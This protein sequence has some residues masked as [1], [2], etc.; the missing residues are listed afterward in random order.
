MELAA[1]AF[2]DEYV[3]VHGLAGFQDD[4]VSIFGEFVGG[5]A[6]AFVSGFL[7]AEAGELGVGAAAI[8]DD[9]AV[10]G[11]DEEVVEIADEAVGAVGGRGNLAFVVD[12]PVAGFHDVFDAEGLGGAAGAHHGDRE[13]GGVE[14][15]GGAEVA[16]EQGFVE[17]GDEKFI[18]RGR[19][20]AGKLGNGLALLGLFQV[21]KDADERGALAFAATESRLALREG[22][23]GEKRHGGKAQGERGEGR[24]ALA[25]KACPN[26]GYSNGAHCSWARLRQYCCT[27]AEYSAG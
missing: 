17:T 9:L 22:G 4:P 6:G 14:R 12:D 18:Q 21:V 23:R 2:A 7:P 25:W 11:D 15:E 5:D 8:E 20:A 1:G 13:L 19:V 16:V 26:S 27:Q 3:D 10:D 24:V